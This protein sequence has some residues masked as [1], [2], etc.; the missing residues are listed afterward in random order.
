MVHPTR[1]DVAG[2]GCGRRVAVPMQ[3]SGGLLHVIGGD[4][5]VF[6]GGR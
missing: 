4:M 6:R 2:F 1:R 5:I 3:R